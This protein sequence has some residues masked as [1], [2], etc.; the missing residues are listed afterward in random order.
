M[1]SRRKPS[2][3][4]MRAAE[5]RDREDAAERLLVQVPDLLTLDLAIEERRGDAAVVESRHVRRINVERAPAMFDLPCADRACADGGHDITR[6]VMTALR[7]GS[8]RF[9][10]EHT[11][12][13]NVGNGT[14]GRVMR[15][16]GTA[17]WRTPS[18]T[19]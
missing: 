8:R 14:C 11:C 5:R 19:G 15:Y 17:T 18:T 13:G 7:A 10:G 16:V 3:A 1:L 2:E 9:E 12:N 6:E 4:A